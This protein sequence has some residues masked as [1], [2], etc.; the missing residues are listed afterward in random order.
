MRQKHHYGWR[1][2]EL[3]VLALLFENLQARAQMLSPAPLPVAQTPL[4]RSHF[5]VFVAQG[6]SQQKTLVSAFRISLNLF[7]AVSVQ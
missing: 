4:W 2:G 1:L 6:E 7:V 5:E 3:A